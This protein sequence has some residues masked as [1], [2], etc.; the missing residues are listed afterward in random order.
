MS[1]STDKDEQ[2][3]QLQRRANFTRKERMNCGIE[4]RVQRVE[5]KAIGNYSQALIPNQE[6]ANLC[7]RS[8]I[9]KQRMV[10]WLLYL[11]LIYSCTCFT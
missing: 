11:R 9:F 2:T 1:T 3:I 10:L 8:Q 4:A 5:L 6:T 7:I